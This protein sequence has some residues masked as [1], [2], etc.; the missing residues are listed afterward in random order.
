M[1]PCRHGPK[2]QEDGKYHL[3]LFPNLLF[4]WNHCGFQQNF[5]FCQ[6]VPY[7]T[8]PNLLYGPRTPVL[9]TR[10]PR[11][12]NLPYKKQKYDV[13]LF[14]A[15]SYFSLFEVKKSDKRTMYI[16]WPVNICCFTCLEMTHPC[17]MAACTAANVLRLIFKIITKCRFGALE[18]Q[19]SSL[20]RL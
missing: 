20:C 17:L 2:P 11:F 13:T 14:R 7:C 18:R 6:Q 5:C 10:G 1:P 12:I 4:C 3:S 9:K 15:T 19:V 8:V 16:T